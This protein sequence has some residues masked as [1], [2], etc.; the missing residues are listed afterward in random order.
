MDNINNFDNIYNENYKED[1]KY[2]YLNY[3]I[4]PTI[5]LKGII[6]IDEIK[7]DLE[8]KLYNDCIEYLK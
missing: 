7:T 5:I 2:Y 4:D 3:S 1:I 8:K 6:N